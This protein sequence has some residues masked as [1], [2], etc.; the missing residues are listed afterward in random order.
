MLTVLKIAIE[1][2]GR[3]AQTFSNDRMRWCYFTNLCVQM[4][5]LTIIN[6]V[7]AASEG[8]E[9]MDIVGSLIFGILVFERFLVGF[10]V[11][12]GLTCNSLSLTFGSAHF[13]SVFADL[14]L[15]FCGLISVEKWP[16]RWR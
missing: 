8:G 12:F 3:G 6:V 14:C 10:Q 16:S 9:G 15:L 1:K 11:R 5:L 4:L 7:T 13:C 2:A